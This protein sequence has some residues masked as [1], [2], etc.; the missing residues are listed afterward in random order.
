[1]GAEAGRAPKEATSRVEESRGQEGEGGVKAEAEKR[2][3]INVSGAVHAAPGQ[4]RRTDRP[5]RNSETVHDSSNL[6]ASHG[7]PRN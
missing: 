6:A 4:P 3:G 1:L 2:S 5:T 7:Y